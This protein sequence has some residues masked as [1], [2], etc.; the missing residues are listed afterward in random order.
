MILLDLPV[1]AF[2]EDRDVVVQ[3]AGR[4]GFAGS[5]DGEPPID[6]LMASLNLDLRLGIAAAGQYAKTGCQKDECQIAGSVEHIGHCT[7]MW[8]LFQPLPW[9]GGRFCQCQWIV[10]ISGP[11]GCSPQKIGILQGDGGGWRAAVGR[12]YNRAEP[13][14]LEIGGLS[15]AVR[16]KS[17]LE[18]STMAGAPELVRG[19]QEGAV[20]C[21]ACGHRCLIPVG[22]SG[23][24]RVRFNQGGELR[25]PAGYVAGVQVDPIEKKPFYHA[26]PGREA[27]SFGMLG[28]DFHCSYCQN[29]VTSQALRDDRA[30]GS[31]HYVQAEEL[32]RLAVES[33]APVA[34][35]TYNEPLITSEWAVEVFRRMREHGIVCGYVSNGNATPEV[36]EFLRPFVDLYKVD[37]KSFDDKA[38]RR[39][40]G[41]LDYVT[42]TIRLLNRMA[43]WV[44]VVTLI[45]PTFNDSDDEVRQMADFLCSVSD[46]IPWHVTAFH[47]DY[48]MTDPPR[49]TAETLLR[50]ADIGK[51]A[52]LKFVYP[53][54]L[55]GAVGER[56]NTCCPACGA[57][58]IRRSGF[59]V[60]EN[61]MVNGRCPECDHAIPGVWEKEA[62]KSS[63][64][65]GIPRAVRL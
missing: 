59:Y 58:C 10:C 16:L 3:A 30:L 40:G 18:E 34:V 1:V 36:L 17:L 19:E 26:F 24:C 53:G 2:F 7:T 14:V 15:M 65:S 38:Y 39:L 22:R 23:V 64:G 11:A 46:E 52:G 55:P 42:E 29:W 12:R 44:E 37:L 54:N 27:L 51:A 49:T 33:K 63:V 57:V 47:P 50:V 56:E 32:V 28:C 43:F 61:R 4:I 45:V 62:P 8:R 48:K 25:V 35:S 20:R 9:R 41:V 13:F 5:G 60:Q 21:L 6:S 31:V